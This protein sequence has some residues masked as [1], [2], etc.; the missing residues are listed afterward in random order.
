MPFPKDK[1][2]QMY[3]GRVQSVVFAFL[4]DYMRKIH[5]IIDLFTKTHA[6]S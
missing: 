1:A 3:K 4:S 2:F 6:H 5:I